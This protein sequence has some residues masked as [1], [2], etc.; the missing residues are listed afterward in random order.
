MRALFGDIKMARIHAR[1]RGKS[2]ST[3][4]VS[5]KVHSWV[6][7]KKK[8]VESLVIKFAK[9]GKNP[10]QIGA[11]LR[12]QYG[13]PD[14]KTITNKKI[15]K[16]LKENNLDKE[17][18]YDL[19]D[20]MKRA[21]KV[22]KHLETHKK[23]KHSKRGLKLIESKILRLAKYYKRKK[24]LPKDWRYSPERAKLIIE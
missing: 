23:D 22:Y 10:A 4:P 13:V 1:K 18:P 2:G 7:Y 17:L 20:L 15:T 24:V 14:V 16:I 21:A 5:P 6:R 12:D 8:E 9:E 3:K 19:L 11:I